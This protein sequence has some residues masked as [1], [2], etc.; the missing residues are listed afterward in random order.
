MIEV[1]KKFTLNKKDEKRLLQDA[2]FLSQNFFTDVYYDTEQ[3]SLTSKD[4][5]L[6]SRDGV[7]ELKLSLHNETNRQVDQY[8]EIT[9]E[10]QIRNRLQVGFGGNIRNALEQSG[11]TP[12]C[13]CKTTRRKYKK[14]NF[15]IDIDLADFND[16]TYGITEIELM[17][18]DKHEVESAVKKITHFAKIHNLT[19]GP[20]RGKIIEY[21]RQMRQSHY[22]KLVESGVVED[23]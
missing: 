13:V 16:F 14:G 11:Y 10:R 5:W 19:I 6:R 22:Q 8:E 9:D 15:I 18:S 4:I 12:F 7:F 21:L 17:V 20:V 3:F 2:E 1:E 23:F